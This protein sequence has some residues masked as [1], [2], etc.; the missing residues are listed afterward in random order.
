MVR[1]LT[2]LLSAAISALVSI[3]AYPQ[4]ATLSD[5]EKAERKRPVDIQYETVAQMLRE[6]D[7]TAPS[8]PELCRDTRM[9]FAY[10][11]RSWDGGQKRGEMANALRA[12]DY[13]RA[14]EIAEAILATNYANIDAHFVAAEVEERSGNAAAATQHR[15]VARGLLASMLSSGNGM[16]RET[17]FVV[18]NA[19][20]EYD[21]LRY[22]LNVE[23]GQQS[24]R[25][26]GFHHYDEIVGRDQQGRSATYFFN[27]DIPYKWH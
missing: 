7:V 9:T 16:S 22:A 3:A 2:F 20:E 10:T 1:V 17:A 12:G 5:K 13:A 4:A 6:A 8:Y 11:R 23:P 26:A 14:L 15:A 18:V 27:T 19:A 24:H 25:T 21:V